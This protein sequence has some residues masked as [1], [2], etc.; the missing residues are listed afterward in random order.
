[1]RLRLNELTNNYAE[2]AKKY[3]LEYRDVEMLFVE[4]LIYFFGTEDVF[5]VS[6]GVE[7]KGK[8]RNIKFKDFKAIASLFNDLCV[9]RAKV[10]VKIFLTV[11]FAERQR[12]VYA[13]VIDRSDYSYTLRLMISKDTPLRYVD[14]LVVERE[15]EKIPDWMQ[16]LPVEV[17]PS[18]LYSESDEDN[19]FKC[20]VAFFNERLAEYH[21]NK[22]LA[23]LRDKFNIHLDIQIK[24]YYR[25]DRILHMK[26][27]GQNKEL[28]FSIVRQIKNY[29]NEFNVTIALKT[30]IRQKNGTK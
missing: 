17:F 12:I 18:T 10:K 21:L 14:D 30:K 19:K 3:A 29:F 13:K 27:V 7:V 4:A 22:L 28:D 5:I 9:A 26:N 1:M 6:E 2:I 20:K 23:K 11:F 24:M 8:Y 15:G 16:L 25:K